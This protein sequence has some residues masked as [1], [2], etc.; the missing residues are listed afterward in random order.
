V[1][2]LM[3]HNDVDRTGVNKSETTLTP[4][5]VN[6][7]T[8]GR[9]HV[10]PLNA[11]GVDRGAIYAQPLYVS[12]LDFGPPRGKRDV[13]YVATMGN[14]VFAIDANT[15]EILAHSW[16][17]NK[18]PVRSQFYFGDNYQD[19][20]KP[21]GRD[22]TIGIL[23]TPVIDLEAKE[24][25]LVLY[26]IDEM[27]ANASGAADA[28]KVEAF[29]YILYALDLTT[30]QKKRSAVITGSV[31]GTGYHNSKRAQKIATLRSLL[32]FDPTKGELAVRSR[33]RSNIPNID[34]IDATGIGTHDPRVHFH[35]MMQLQRPGLLLLAPGLFNALN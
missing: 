6:V 34:V 17:E 24:L 23:S 25:F 14:W 5:N 22:P 2:I 19:I 18:A 31:S 30:L 1:N 16:I 9:L 29:Q 26:T 3:Q 8:F 28:D 11:G 13:V 21:S 4:G 33:F 10:T 12:G 32:K 7:N 15:G 27:K 35:A 20:V